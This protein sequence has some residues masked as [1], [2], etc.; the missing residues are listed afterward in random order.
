M[1]YWFLLVVNSAVALVLSSKEQDCKHWGRFDLLGLSKDGDITFGGIFDV[2]SYQVEHHRL[3]FTEHPDT[4]K[5]LSFQFRPFRWALAMI[6]AIEEI[7][8]D[9]ALLPGV[10]LGYRLYDS[11]KLTQL[12]LKAALAFLNKPEANEPSVKCKNSSSVSAIVADS[13]STRSLAI[14]PS[15]GTFRIPMVSYFATCA[16]LSNRKEYPSFFRTIPSD[17]YQATALAQLVKHFGWTWIGTVKSDDDYGNFGMQ[18]F[19]EAVQELGVCIAFSASFHITHA[20]EKLMKTIDTIKTSSTKVVVAFVGESN[21]RTLLKEMIRQNVSGIQWIGTESWVS[22]LLLP[23]EESKK[24]ATGTIGI[25]IRKFGIPGLREFL[26]K[27]HPTLYPENLLLLYYMRTVNF[28]TKIGEKVYFDE[29]GDPVATYDIVN[30]QPNALGDIDIV[31]VGHYDGSA[32]SG[33]EFSITE[34]VIVWSGGQKSL[35]QYLKMVNFTTMT[36]ETMH[37]NENGDPIPKYDI[38]HWQSTGG[39][40]DVVTV[41]Y[42]DGSATPGEEFAINEESVVW[43]DGEERTVPSDLFQAKALAQFVEHFGWTWIGTIGGD[44]EYGRSGIQAFSELVQRAGVCIAFSETILRTYSKERILK[45]VGTIKMS[46]AKVILAFASEGDLYPLLKEV[47]RQNITGIQWVASEAWI[48]AARPSTKDNFKS[49]GGTIGF[50][51]RKMAIP[52][53]KDFLLSLRPSIHS[54][55]HFVNVFW[56]TIFGCT[57]NRDSSVFRAKKCTGREKLQKVNNSFFD[58]TQ[59]RVSYNVYKAVYAIAHALHSLLFCEDELLGAYLCANV[60]NIEPWQ[61]LKEVRFTNRFDEHVYFD[62][63]GD[64]TASYD[65]INWQ[66]KQNGLVEHVTVGYFDASAATGNKF[67]I[68]ED[69]IIWHGNKTKVPQSVCSESCPP[70]TRK[71]VQHRQHA[72]CF[73]CIPCSEGEITNATGQQISFYHLMKRYFIF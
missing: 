37:F 30:W 9:T 32:R 31:N 27:V 52:K 39:G 62:P 69:S 36:G 64:P 47:V 16:C 25:A 67:M 63:N 51:S 26:M 2:H 11:C 72:C 43:S 8:N 21:M 13:G 20:Q 12:S 4:A 56:E 59:L 65:I 35:L 45:I 28:I 34:G 73:D 48:T 10:T 1:D 44:N 19:E 23:P 49:L 40:T 58:V 22:S 68:N 14:A 42:Y 41:G 60:S 61:H 33:K 29:N 24:I 50:A 55:D 54:T 7:N 38:I 17:Y 6:F 46:T 3:S 53:F 71:A 15:I 70:G 18:A 66:M 57:F 5:C